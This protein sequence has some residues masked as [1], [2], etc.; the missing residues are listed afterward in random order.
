MQRRPIVPV[1]MALLAAA[2]GACGG[3]DEVPPADS[4]ALEDDAITVGSFDFAESRLLG[5][6]YGQALEAAGF[7]V[8][9]AIDLGPRELVAPALVAGLIEFVPEYAG[10]AL[11]FHRR[12][13]TPSFDPET[14]HD[15]LADA[16]E[17]VRVVA[18]AAAPAQNANAFVVT[19]RTAEEAGLRT[20]SDLAA[21]ADELTFGGPPECPTRVLCLVGLEE[22]YGVVFGTVVALDA[23]GPTTHQA[24]LDGG[25]DVALLFSSD[26]S[27]AT[28]GFVELVDDREL[29][30]AENVTPLV[31]TEVVERWGQDLVSVVDSVSAR[32]TDAELRSLNGQLGAGTEIATVA[33]R[34]LRDQELT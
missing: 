15:L 34:W 7:E 18:L 6:I 30:P 24:L 13:D 4:S 10:S 19:R 11:R 9:R 20:I 31:R 23:G 3:A 17:G 2:L 16:L 14:T 1:I 5:E 12:V 21:V 22:T 8:R 25:V 33:E 32:L 26:P 28:H 27:L 29:Q